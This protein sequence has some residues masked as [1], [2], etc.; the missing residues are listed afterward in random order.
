MEHLC[1]LEAGALDAPDQRRFRVVALVVCIAREAL[2]ARNAHQKGPARPQYPMDLSEQR[3][4]SHQMLEH[5]IE[6]RAIEFAIPERQQVRL[7]LLYGES[8]AAAIRHRSWID[9]HP[10]GLGAIA[11]QVA[12]A[13]ADIQ[14]A[15]AQMPADPRIQP[16]VPIPE[17]DALA[18]YEAVEIVSGLSHGVQR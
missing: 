10:N 17:P 14:H 15:T 8:T 6:H 3:V 7:H 13:A 9:V 2:L 11:H 4:G 5:I 12:D 1:R 18:A 16:G